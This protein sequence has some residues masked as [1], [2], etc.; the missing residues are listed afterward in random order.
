M[1][2]QPTLTFL[3]GLEDS[4]LPLKPKVS[5]PSDS[6]RLTPTPVQS[7]K[8]IGPRFVIGA[9]LE[10]FQKD[11]A[12]MFSPGDLHASPQVAP[13]SEK[14]RLM[15]AGSGRK[16][17]QCYALSGRRSQC[18]KTLLGF[19]LLM[20]EWSSSI[21][22]LKWKVRA[23]KSSRSLFQLVPLTPRT[24]ATGFGLYPTLE[25]S[26]ATAGE[27]RKVIYLTRSGRP[28]G[29]SNQGI[30]G[31]IGL[32]RFVKLLPTLRANEKGD[33]QNDNAD[34]SKP[35]LSLTGMARLLPTLTAVTDTGGAAL[36]KMGGARSRKVF[37]EML[38]EDFN[39][40]LNPQWCEWF[41]GYPIG[42]TE[43]NASETQSFRKSRKSSP[44]QSAKPSKTNL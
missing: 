14:A 17:W 12:P 28:R 38:P 29:M 18:L 42:W 40:A 37:K 4:V 41:M 36:C 43:L 1:K 16:L 39:G 25:A 15:T 13:A 27:A 9:T 20:T 32:A 19:L 24:G 5:A 6:V 2:S 3:A 11:F 30:D 10:T 23:T 22:L 35:R 33:Y 7:S 8:S 26:S 44:A 21:C 31:S 34:K